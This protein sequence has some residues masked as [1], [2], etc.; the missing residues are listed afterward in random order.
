VLFLEGWSIAGGPIQMKKTVMCVSL[1]C[2]TLE[3]V[4]NNFVTL[5]VANEFSRTLAVCAK[6]L[7]NDGLYGGF[8]EL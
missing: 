4:L 7:A 6:D 1:L 3:D 2:R 5:A 8:Q